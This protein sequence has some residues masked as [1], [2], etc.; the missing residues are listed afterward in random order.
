[1]GKCSAFNRA[2]P[3]LDSL[4]EAEIAYGHPVL[5]EYSFCVKAAWCGSDHSPNFPSHTVEQG[6]DQELLV[7]RTSLSG[8]GVGVCGCGL[9]ACVRACARAH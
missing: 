8:I 6:N 5:V 1:M 4:L 7:S 9:R 3:Q 2:W